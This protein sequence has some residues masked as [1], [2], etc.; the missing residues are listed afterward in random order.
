MEQFAV[1]DKVAYPAHGV[2][3]IISIESK[4]I[5]GKKLNFYV[6]KVLENGM[7]LMVPK[8]NANRIGMRNIISEQEAEK[9]FK[10]LSKKEKKNDLITWNR[11]Y[12]EYM[13]KIKTGSI[14]NLAII[15]RE[16]IQL[17]TNKDLSFGERKI[18]DT[19]KTLLICE[20]SIAKKISYQEVE[21]R[22]NKIFR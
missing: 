17:K 5:A 7:K 14:Y 18:L 19:A 22:L 2:S 21:Y 20:L 15:L 12:R 11:R 13:E 8:K 16:L 9:V 3:E 1:G 6:L 10:I 4:T